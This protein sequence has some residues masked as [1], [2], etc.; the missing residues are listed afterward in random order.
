MFHTGILGFDA[1]SHLSIPLVPSVGVPLFS[2]IH[3]LSVSSSFRDAA[4]IDEGA[5]MTLH[6][7]VAL[8]FL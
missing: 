3:L 6:L 8:I 5:G 4:D 2:P 7:Y 1:I